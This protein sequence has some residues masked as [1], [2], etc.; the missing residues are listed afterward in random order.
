MSG[1]RGS[2]RRLLVVSHAAVTP[3]NLS[4]Y[5]HLSAA[6]WNVSVVIPA[7][8]RS[9]WGGPARVPVVDGF[10][11]TILP[12]PT[13]L[14]GNIPLHHYP[15]AALVRTVDRVRP[16]VMYIEEE[17][18]AWSAFQ[19]ARLAQARGIPFAVYSAQNLV[20]SYPP[21][22]AARESWVLAHAADV[23]AIT[24]DVAEALRRKGRS[25]PVHQVP[26]WLAPGA[27][28]PEEPP[29]GAGHDPF[30]VGYA[31]R[32]VREK[33]I[34]VLLGGFA[35]SG[36]EDA[37]LLVAGS[38]PLLP[39]VRA[40]AAR[41]AAA[42][43]PRLRVLGA[44]AHGDVARFLAGLDVLVLPS[45]D[46]AAWSEQFGRVIVEAAAQ[47]VP[48]IGS[49]AGWIPRLLAE[50]GGTCIEQ[51]D[52]PDLAAALRRCRQEWRTPEWRRQAVA[53]RRAAGR[54]HA[55]TV[56]AELSAVLEAALERG[57]GA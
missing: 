9:E 50:L 10:P 54:Y 2:G 39:A 26:L 1:G 17:P 13:R 31:G 55:R 19:A 43:G 30:T 8:W 38:G 6:G 32:L 44:L 51:G 15:T 47:G 21:P 42:D 22:F 28:G 5:A 27:L 53:R 18:Y 56:A 29:A 57:R 14:S 35:A 37:L 52:V 41:W 36:L 25:G 11:G 7:R 4:P 3:L 33:G 48:A 20:K 34:D 23:V 49:R 45:R 24:A 16:S 40:T 12:L 46:T